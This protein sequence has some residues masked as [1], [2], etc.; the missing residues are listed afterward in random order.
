MGTY[1][2]GVFG[3]FNGKV[4]SVVASKWKG[5]KVVKNYPE[6]S[7]KPKSEPQLS[8]TS[9]FGLVGSFLKRA[10][11]LISV[12]YQGVSGAVTPW[13]IALKYHLKEAITGTYPNFQLKYEMVRLSLDDSLMSQAH[14]VKAVAVAGAMV[15]VSWKMETNADKSTLPTDKAYILLYNPAKKTSLSVTG[16][17][18]RSGLSVDLPLPG[19]FIGDV[20]YGWLFF[21]SAN[22]KIVSETQ[23]LGSV[24]VIE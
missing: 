11:A 10:S 22:G 4:G 3:T 2:P 16:W 14:D 12:G 18:L 6:K 19:Y 24:T 13:N 7:T 20:L 1:N 5:I 8:H 21:T 9:K 23:Y 15:K 17:V